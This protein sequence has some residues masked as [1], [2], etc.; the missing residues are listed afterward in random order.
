MFLGFYET[1]KTDA[2]TFRKI[3]DDVLLR[4]GFSIQQLRGQGFDGGS[5]M[6][7]KLVDLQ[8]RILDENYKA[9]YF[10]C[11]GNQLNVVCQDACAANPKV[12]Q[13]MRHIN[14][15]IN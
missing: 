9:L 13:A 10:H 3:V 11:K 5:N 4:F 14:T 7:G 15:I 2:G 1:S 12:G 6:Y 8:K